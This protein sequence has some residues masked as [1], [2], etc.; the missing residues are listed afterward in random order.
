MDALSP[1]CLISDK[2][3]AVFCNCHGAWTF[4]LSTIYG[5]LRIAAIA[6]FAQFAPVLIALGHKLSARVSLCQHKPTTLPN[7]ARNPSLTPQ[8]A[9]G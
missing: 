7:P 3:N 1:F 4:K 5:I 9:P 2:N 8:V 6:C